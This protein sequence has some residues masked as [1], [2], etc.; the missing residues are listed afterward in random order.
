MHFYLICMKVSFKRIYI[1]LSM[2]CFM[3]L[4]LNI[5]ERLLHSI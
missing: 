4:R 1:N 2:N 3:M 5:E